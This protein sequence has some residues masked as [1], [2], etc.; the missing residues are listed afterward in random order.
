M[1]CLIDEL[2][3]ELYLSPDLWTKLLDEL[4]LNNIYSHH[5]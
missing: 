4:V 2:N 3:R 1:E 5:C